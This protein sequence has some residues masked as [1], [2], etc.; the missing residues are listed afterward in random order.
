M[1]TTVTMPAGD[2][3]SIAEILGLANLATAWSTEGQNYIINHLKYRM[4]L[5]SA[6]F[7]TFALV[8]V[9][10]DQS[11]PTWDEADG[12]TFDT[13]EEVLQAAYSSHDY[14]VLV[15]PTPAEPLD[16]TPY[17]AKTV[18]IDYTLPR[19]A[20]EAL[21]EEVLDDEDLNITLVLILWTENAAQVVEARGGFSL[22]RTLAPSNKGLV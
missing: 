2:S 5:F 1:K 10:S 6:D 15:P 22:R 16:S 8:M 17:C 11:T 14:R 4:Q 20:K 12:S 18:N 7:F 3:V 9:G 21:S 13:I 19:A